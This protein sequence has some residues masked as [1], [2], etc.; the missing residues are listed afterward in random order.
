MCAWPCMWALVAIPLIRSA[1][2]A[3]SHFR[4]R[5]HGPHA[6]GTLVLRVTRSEAFATRNV[7]NLEFEIRAGDRA[8][9]TLPARMPASTGRDSSSIVSGRTN[10]AK[11]AKHGNSPP[12]RGSSSRCRHRGDVP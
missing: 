10:G 6:A 7:P 1:R 2:S 12:P 3:S 11:Q 8:G 9:L 5:T 4:P